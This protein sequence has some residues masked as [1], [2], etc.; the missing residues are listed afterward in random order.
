MVATVAMMA[1]FLS[2]ALVLAVQ[3]VVLRLCD[4][5]FFDGFGEVSLLWPWSIF[6]FQFLISLF[7]SV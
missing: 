7:N 2:F 6:V 1:A 4:G 3:G 5:F